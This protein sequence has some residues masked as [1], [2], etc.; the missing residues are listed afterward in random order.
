MIE[1]RN[2]D[3]IVGI[4]GENVMKTNYVII[5]FANRRTYEGSLRNFQKNGTGIMRENGKEYV[6]DWEND[7]KNGRGFE[8]S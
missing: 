1:S 6:G 7:M 5:E 2:G 3:I 4:W 8:K